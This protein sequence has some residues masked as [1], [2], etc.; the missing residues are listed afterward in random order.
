MS[1][2]SCLEKSGLPDSEARCEFR[3]EVVIAAVEGGGSR[4]RVSEGLGDDLCPRH[5]LA[6]ILCC[7]KKEDSEDRDP[8]GDRGGLGGLGGESPL[9][10]QGVFFPSLV[11]TLLFACCDSSLLGGLEE[12][13]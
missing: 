11:P 13:A 10:S 2:R 3:N 4:R 8:G 6:L 1:A 5:Q 12:V 9:A 7:G